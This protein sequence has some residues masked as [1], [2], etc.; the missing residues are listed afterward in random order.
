MS[1][2]EEAARKRKER[3]RQVFSAQQTAAAD[4]TSAE[5]P[6]KVEQTIEEV[7][8]GIV[9]TTLALQREEA[10]R[11]DLDITAVAPKRAN[12]DLKRDLQKQL[13][14]LKPLNDAAV[15]D[16]VRKRVQASK[17]AEGLADVVEAHMRSTQL[18]PGPVDEH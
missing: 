6:A 13:D 16:L 2:L 5:E 4:A 10:Q 3:L 17:D 14:A 1:A 7:V 11:T 9:E 8:S 18:Q 12:W 15:A